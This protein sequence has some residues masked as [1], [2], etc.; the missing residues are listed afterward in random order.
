MVV[1]LGYEAAGLRLVYRLSGTL[2]QLRIPSVHT[3]APAERLWA[4]TCFEAFVAPRSD[5]GY[6]EWNF[7]PSGQSAEYAFSGYRERAP[8]SA[9][10]GAFAAPAVHVH[11]MAD[12]LQL[13]ARIV[14][15][16]LR[17]A[18]LAIGLS[19]VVEDAGGGLSY[20]ALHHPSARPD[21]HHREGFVLSLD[22]ATG[23]FSI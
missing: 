9:D 3:P 23:R 19:A 12:S 18:E 6:R 16:R 7:S 22:L 20:W 21:F 1:E 17:C 5:N 2:A 13:E 11:R 10:G 15:P 4:N 14:L 8:S